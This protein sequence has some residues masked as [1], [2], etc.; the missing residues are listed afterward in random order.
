MNRN[1][2]TTSSQPTTQTSELHTRGTLKF[3]DFVKAWGYITPES[4]RDIYIPGSV[5]SNSGFIRCPAGTPLEVWYVVEARGP[6]A[7]RVAPLG[8]ID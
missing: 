4:G 3:F 2:A 6:R 7:L 5:L 1:L 8:E